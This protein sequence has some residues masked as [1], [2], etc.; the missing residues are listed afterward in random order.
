MLKS[1]RQESVLA[2]L[3]ARGSASVTEIADALAVSP[4]T[5]RRDIMAL[6]QAGTLTRTWGGA[7]ILSDVDDPFQDLSLIHI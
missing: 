3:Q 6:E 4:A 7:Q 5:A 2:L 1:V